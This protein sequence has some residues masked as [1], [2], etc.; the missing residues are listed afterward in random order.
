[1]HSPRAEPVLNIVGHDMAQKRWNRFRLWQNRHSTRQSLATR[2][3]ILYKRSTVSMWIPK[4]SILAPI[5]SQAIAPHLKRSGQKFRS[6][7]RRLPRSL[8]R[9]R[10]PVVLPTLPVRHRAPVRVQLWL[11]LHWQ[12]MLHRRRQDCKS[13][14]V[15]WRRASSFR[16]AL[17]FDRP[18]TCLQPDW[19]V[20]PREFTGGL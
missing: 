5:N 19:F 13:E 3:S 17:S 11:M 10:V 8:A 15:W 16:R 4:Y 12:L 2:L 1:M 7:E 9:G 14:R 6:A 18:Q 20:Y